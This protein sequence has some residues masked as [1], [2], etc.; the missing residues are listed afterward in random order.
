MEGGV[1][2]ADAWMRMQRREKILLGAVVVGLLGTVTLFGSMLWLLWKESVASEA[3]YAGGLAATLGQRTEHIIV[4]IRDM[5]AGFDKLEATRC[6]PAH[7]EALQNAAVSR[8]YIRGIGYWHAADRVCGVGFLPQEGLKPPHADRIYDNGVIAWWP[9]AQTE[10]GSVQLFLMRYGDHDVAIDPRL[11]LDLPPS[12]DRRATL[13]VENL[14][15]SAIPWDAQLPQPDALP[16]GV[17][18]EREQGQVTSHFARNQILPIDVVA[19]EPI[20]NFWSRHSSTLLIGA[21]LGLLL[22]AAWIDVILRVSRYQLQPATE[23]RH[24]L[25]SGQISVQYQP[26][27]DLRTS[28]CIG[29][30]ALA[31]WRREKGQWVSPNAFIPI[32][33]E[34]GL[35]QEITLAVL[36]TVVADLKNIV[37]EAGKISIN[38]N[39]SPDDLKND[40]V[41]TELIANLKAAG[42][43]AQAIKL[44]ITERALVNS[45]VARALISGF[46]ERG[47]KV[48]VDDFGTGYSSLSYL[49]SFE[50]DVLKIDKSFVDAI[51]TGAATGEVIVHVI[52]MAKS[53]GLEVVAEGVET[54]EQVRWL[55]DHGVFQGQGYLFSKPLTVGDF[56]EFVRAKN[57]RRK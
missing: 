56:I 21:V 34:A 35:I 10:V 54:L 50:L 9:S 3:D 43:P 26:V 41:G 57:A 25:A 23:L 17:K 24:A 42:L 33:E 8:P 4:D 55:V 49:Q 36:R 37:A 29:A 15:L 11:L 53:L 20:S 46:R 14:R 30:E 38:L 1:R 16:V 13:W 39:L 45:D 22:I 48:A 2:A 27:V 31:R 44:E 28:R 6:S 5:L 32:A 12:P 7:F 52:D 40:R 51:G 19:Q 18:I 47:H